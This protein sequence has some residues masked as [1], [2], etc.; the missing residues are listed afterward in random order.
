M[1]GRKAQYTS[2]ADKQRAYRERQKAQNVTLRNCPDC[3]GDSLFDVTNELPSIDFGGL[4]G[5]KTYICQ[6]CFKGIAVVPNTAPR[7]F[8]IQVQLTPIGHDY[9]KQGQYRD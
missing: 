8:E 4:M 2:A 1:A 3:G 5:G 7:T 9:A 6:S